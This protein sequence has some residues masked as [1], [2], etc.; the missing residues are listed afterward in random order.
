[1]TGQILFGIKLSKN[2][3]ESLA[4]QKDPTYVALSKGGTMTL[5]M[6]SRGAK[7]QR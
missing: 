1:M 2:W 7:I 5:M 3:K 6:P 4:T